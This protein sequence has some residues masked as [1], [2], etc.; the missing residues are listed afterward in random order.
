ML[1]NV[2]LG[3]IKTFDEDKLGDLVF[4]EIKDELEVL[5]WCDQVFSSDLDVAIAQLESSLVRLHGATFNRWLVLWMMA[6]GEYEETSY[7]KHSQ[8]VFEEKVVSMTRSL[9]SRY[10][11]KET[12][13]SLAQ[14]AECVYDRKL[15]SFRVTVSKMFKRNRPSVESLYVWDVAETSG[16][17]PLLEITPGPA[18][19]QFKKKVYRVYALKRINAFSAIHG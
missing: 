13:L 6:L 2:N 10:D 19:K 14:V 15:S 18:L 12:P 3:N 9:M 7:E 16:K 8:I 4:E 11:N 1:N 5:T 17:S